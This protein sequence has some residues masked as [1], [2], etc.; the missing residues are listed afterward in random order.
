MLNLKRSLGI[1]MGGYTRT[2]TRPI[3][4]LA[5]IIANI[6]VYAVSS[7]QR[8]FMEIDDY[9][10]SAGG[11]VPS[12]IAMPNQLYRI[13]SS[14]FLHADFFH[15]LFNMYF[16]YLFGRAVEEALG[17]LRFLIL[18]IFSGVAASIFHT[19]FSFLGGATAYVIPAIGA[20]GAISGVLGAYLILY[21]GTSLTMGWFFFYMPVLF[22]MKAAYYLIFWFATQVIYGYA[23]LGGSTAVFAHAGGFIAGIAL[24]PLVASEKR[25]SQFRLTRQQALFPAYVIFTP[26]SVKSAGLGTATKVVI[27]VL[28]VS[29]LFGAAYASSGLS[30]R[31]DVKAATLRYSF[32]GTPYMDYVGLQLQNV[33]YQLS[34][35][36]MDETRILLNRLYAAELL[37]DDDK[38]GGTLSLTDWNVKL[39]MR[40]GNRPVSVNLTVAYFNGTY[41]EDGF[42]NHGQGE[43]ETQVVLIDYYGRPSVSDYLVHYS[44]ELVSL[45]VNLTSITQ[46]TGMMSLVATAFA[47]MV[48]LTKDRDLTLI[49]EEPERPWQ[50]LSPYV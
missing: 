50:P 27:T 28:L 39:V 45:T 18:Y 22:R 34:Q 38:A 46:Y 20:S 8:F 37:Y 2:K 44:F 5:L 19:A 31:G 35:V 25:L 7:Y 3:T 26:E 10:V 40:V 24:L 36:S 9:W 23:R 11:F 42:L 48:A 15:I 43:L 30:I 21:P 13:F 33:E 12:L 41:D 6:A 29:L 1:P 47:L 32:E 16:L 17:K 4:T 14:M 49:G